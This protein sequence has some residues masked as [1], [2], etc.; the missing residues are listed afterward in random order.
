MRARTE[1]KAASSEVNID[2]R[3]R[4]LLVEV[5]SSKSWDDLRM[6]VYDRHISYDT[7][8]LCGVQM[9]HG[10]IVSANLLSWCDHVPA[11]ACKC[12]ERLDSAW[13][14]CASLE[15]FRCKKCQIIRYVK[16]KQ[17]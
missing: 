15:G 5:L 1:K 10:Y 7:C 17:P 13:F 8:P 11:L 2:V 9:E 3:S 12:G 14:G 4:E 16:K 6:P